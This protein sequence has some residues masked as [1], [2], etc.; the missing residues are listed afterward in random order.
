MIKKRVNLDLDSELWKQAKLA[1]VQSDLQ[2]REWV[3][4]A[5]KEKLD[6]VEQQRVTSKAPTG[7]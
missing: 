4:N 5:I 3:T 2:L 1:A 7:K 6:R